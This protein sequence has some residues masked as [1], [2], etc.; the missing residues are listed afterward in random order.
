MR[1]VMV[2]NSIA[3]RNGNELA[4]LDRLAGQRIE[5][6][7]HRHVLVE[8]H[9]A[10]GD[11]GAFGVLDAGFSRRLFCLISAARSSSVSI[12]P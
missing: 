2:M 8:R 7:F 12:L 9:Q 4:G 5:R 6:Q 10:L 3:L 1:L 11:A